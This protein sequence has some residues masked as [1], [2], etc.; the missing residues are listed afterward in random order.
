MSLLGSSPAVLVGDFWLARAVQLVVNTRHFEWAVGEFS[1]TLTDLAE[2]EMLQQQKACTCDTTQEDY[3]RIIYGKTASLFRLA[4]LAGARSVD[5]PNPFETALGTYGQ[6]VGMAFQIKDDI[7]DYTGEQL[8]KP[9]G[10]D[11]MER[12]ITAP[13]LGALREDP[14]GGEIRARLRDIPAH[15]SDAAE[16][17][18]YVLER[19]GIALAQQQLDA[20]ILQAQQ[21]LELLPPSQA[22]DYLTQTAHYIG[23]REK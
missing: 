23:E 20:F 22:K 1:Q 6:A 2:G 18:R 10:L 3:H 11:L 13:L 14:Q 4:C 8:G 7:L 15:P 12:K 9:V 17:R 19:G 5:A 21:A 16:I